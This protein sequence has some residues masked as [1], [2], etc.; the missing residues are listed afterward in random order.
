MAFHFLQDSLFDSRTYETQRQK[1]YLWTYALS[2]YV[3]S[4]QSLRCPH[5]ETLHTWLSKIRPVKILIRL[6]E[7]AV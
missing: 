2:A 3:R 4:D 1:T 6:R 5:E 7:C